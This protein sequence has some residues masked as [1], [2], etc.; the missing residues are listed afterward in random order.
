MQNGPY[1]WSEA[2]ESW[3]FQGGDIQRELALGPEFE[4][5]VMV[6]EVV[7]LLLYGSCELYKES[8]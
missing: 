2:A 7:M 5:L 8:S 6:L 3:I 1:G 4:H